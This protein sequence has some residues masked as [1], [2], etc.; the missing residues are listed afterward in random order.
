MELVPVKE[1]RTR[2]IRDHSQLSIRR[3]CELLGL[4]RSG[5]YYNPEGESA[6]NLELMRLIDEEY[7]RHPFYGVPRLT[8]YLE[9][10]GCPV[11]HKRVERLMKQMGISG[12]CPKKRLSKKM[13]GHRI[14]PYL[15]KD[16]QIRAPNQ[17]WSTDITYIRLVQGFIYLVAV[18]DWFSRYVLSWKISNTLGSDFCIEALKDAL[19]KEAQPDIFNTDQGS[20][21]TGNEFTSVLK[22][23]GIA[24]S[25]DSKGRAFDNIFIERL[26]RSVKYEEVYLKQYRTVLEAKKGLRDYFEFYNRERPHQS[27]GYQT[28]EEIYLG[29]E[30]VGMWTSPAD[31]P[32]PYGTCG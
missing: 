32:K 29:R 25:M 13:E 27:L 18:I 28:P 2:I 1:R 12:I 23:R 8:V 9:R 20:Q 30:P 4:N 16:V 21:F 5:C 31:Q 26:W 6:Y 3:Q 10:L 17:V 22:D 7:T 19:M 15:L 11:N 14:Y 24:I